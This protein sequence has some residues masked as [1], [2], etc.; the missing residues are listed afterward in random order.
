MMRYLILAFLFSGCAV[1]RSDPCMNNIITSNLSSFSNSTVCFKTVDSYDLDYKNKQKINIYGNLYFPEVEAK[2]YNA[3][4]LSHGSGGL[5]RYHKKYVELLNSAGYVVFQLDHYMGRSIK[6]DKTFSK[7]SGIT[8]MNDAYFALNLLRTHP[9]ID[10]IAYIGWSQGGVGPILSHFNHISTKLTKKNFDASVAI[11]P[12]CGF[13]FNKTVKTDTPL[14]II[15]G[16]SDDLT[17]EKSCQNIHEKFQTADNLIEYI[18]IEDARHGFDNPFLFFGITF[19]DL[20]S[21]NIINDKCTLTI[22]DNGEIM[23]LN[24][25]LI[26]GPSESEKLLKECSTPGVTVQYS[27]RA[28]NLTSEA[29]IN[30]FSERLNNK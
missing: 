22:T 4:I 7:V 21:L 14:L 10:K 17:P 25:R 2:Q 27:R 30:F 19:D 20:P 15:T 23:N 26:P 18:S 9:K 5:R 12:Y 8:F 28:T 1:F 29:I 6:Y 13:T 11:Y 24:G 16:R 3:V